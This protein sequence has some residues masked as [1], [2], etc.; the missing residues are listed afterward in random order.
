MEAGQ[1]FK[2]NLGG[3]VDWI[4]AVLNVNLTCDHLFM[5]PVCVHFW[6]TGLEGSSSLQA[7]GGHRGEQ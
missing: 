2:S 1:F 6:G 7:V 5:E 4:L 3:N